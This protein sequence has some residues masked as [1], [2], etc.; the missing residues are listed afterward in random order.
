MAKKK[1]AGIERR[2][3]SS[4]A[5]SG[6]PRK[7]KTPKRVG[8]KAREE[9]VKPNF[10]SVVRNKPLDV[11]PKPKTPNARRSMALG[12]GPPHPHIPDDEADDGKTKTKL[13]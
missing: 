8:I 1:A 9:P 6:G 13:P 3:G 7:P 12:D 10:P 2:H 11:P 4:K 5:S